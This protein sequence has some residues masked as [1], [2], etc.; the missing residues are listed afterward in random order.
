MASELLLMYHE[1]H[2]AAKLFAGTGISRKAY[3]VQQVTD[4][5]KMYPQLFVT[6]GMK[7]ELAILFAEHHDDGRFLQF[8]TIGS[9]SDRQ[10]SHREAGAQMLDAFCKEHLP[11]GREIPQDVLFLRAVMLYHGQLC[12]F[13]TTTV[14]ASSIPYIMAISAADELENSMSCV[15]YLKRNYYDDEKKL[16]YDDTI[17]DE[18]WSFYETATKFDKMLYCHTYAE[19]ILFAA[20]L[21]VC[22]CHKYG[23]FAKDLFKLPGYGYMS[24][25]EGFHDIFFELLSEQDACRAYE[26]LR[27][28][29]CD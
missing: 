8:Q 6:P 15:S 23:N 19:Y 1:Q 25:L 7:H 9:L 26:I 20:T 10:F 27:H 3:H 13:D 14:P 5:V 29:I 28:Y 12:K 21:A 24:T 22:S 16:S 11:S 4:F 2:R 18:V 17:S